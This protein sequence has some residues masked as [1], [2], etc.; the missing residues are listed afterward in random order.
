VRVLVTGASGFVARDI[1]ETF[2]GAG[3]VVRGLT[4]GLGV[5]PGQYLEVARWT[6]VHDTA[7]LRLALKD[8]DAVIHLA[9]RVHVMRESAADALDEFRRVNSDGSTHVLQESIAVGVS[10]F[11]LA[12]TV[13]AVGE[14]NTSPWTE[15]TLP[16]P[17]DP[18]GISKWEA[19]QRVTD[20]ATGSST[21]VSVLRLPM[22]YGPGMKGNMPRLFRLVDRGMPLPF[23]GLE[24]R[25]SM[26]F[27]GNVAAAVKWLVLSEKAASDTF[28]VS[29]DVAPS[30]PQLIEEIGACLGTTPRLFRV[31]RATLSLIGVA[32]DLVNQFT[33]FPVS[34]AEVERLTESLVVDST[35]LTRLMGVPLPYPWATGIA[36]TADWY[37]STNR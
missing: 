33:R 34:S 8:V 37:R 16:K 3:H 19:E 26:A 30:T 22:V 25:R 7:A 23:A 5:R 29:D 2:I 9:A 11:V 1:I 35:K 36:K 15:S 20:L 4:R 32:G 12:S 21:A 27:C 24:N 28:F 14:C 13:K 6:G 10:R 17:V 18:Y 31:P